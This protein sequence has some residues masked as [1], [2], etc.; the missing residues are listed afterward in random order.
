MNKVAGMT[1]GGVAAIG[2]TGTAA[3][4]ALVFFSGDRPASSPVDMPVAETSQAETSKAPQKAR[5]ADAPA[6]DD[7]V[8]PQAGA[9]PQTPPGFD[10]V[11]VDPNG[12]AL[13]AGTATAGAGVLVLLDGQEKD[14]V[15]ADGT[16][17]FVSFL[18]L[19]PN[20]LPRVLSLRLV[21]R[22]GTVDSEDRV[23]IAPRSV[24]PPEDLASVEPA[25]RKAE[26]S[27]AKV[28]QPGT[29]PNG[30]VASPKQKTQT[31]QQSA[32]D[33]PAPPDTRE[34]PDDMARTTARAGMNAATDPTEIAQDAQEA[35]LAMAGASA[36]NIAV[37][38]PATGRTNRPAS[39]TLRSSDAIGV[40][41]RTSPSESQ[42]DALARTAVSVP[43][44]DTVPAPT[45]Q[46]PTVILANREGLR[47]LQTPSDG[48][49]QAVALDAIT[50]SEAGDV[51]LSGRGSAQGFV[52]VYLDN[53]PVTTSRIAQDGN[54]RAELPDVDSGV[55]TLRIDE[56][57]DDGT[58]ISRVESPFKR[59][60]PASLAAG[61]GTG[62]QQVQAL[63]VQPG[64][65]LWA[66]AN[67]RYGDGF[68][69]V[70]VFRAN[71]DRI[72]NPDLIYPG[73]IFALPDDD[74]GD[75]GST[76]TPE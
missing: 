6:A 57:D 23:I 61:L 66:I 2:G 4:L 76:A 16:G 37:E 36:D 41:G 34:M 73:Q 60:S 1:L 14:K 42:P 50:Y 72:R 55:Y 43:Q 45:P 9:E 7:P 58:V 22:D 38:G 65:T 17:R 35:G 30:A 51:A 74:T 44:P 33:I 20:D 70:R 54:W 56:V 47:V 19:P 71:A 10:I 13:I 28:P 52:R 26:V 64:D 69:Y 67:D 53:T 49:M 48:A 11:R 68:L 12:A 5:A 25:R 32:A 46:A 62:A 24:A 21:T 39:S 15:E 18:S 3:I 29:G 31:P 27:G 59:E 40:S 8:A 63:T 75:A